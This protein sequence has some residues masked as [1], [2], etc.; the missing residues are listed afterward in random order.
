[1]TAKYLSLEVMKVIMYIIYVEYFSVHLYHSVS[2]CLLASKQRNWIE[3]IIG[4]IGD[5]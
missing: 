2:L 4:E 5:G 1:M 3:E